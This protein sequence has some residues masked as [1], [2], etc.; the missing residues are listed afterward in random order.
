MGT[1]FLGL[2]GLQTPPNMLGLL[3][4]WE[5]KGVKNGKVTCRLF[6]NSATV[7]FKPAGQTPPRPLLCL[8]R[9]RL[10]PGPEPAAT[11][12]SA[13]AQRGANRVPRARHLAARGA[14]GG[15]RIQLQ[16]GSVHFQG[17]GSN[18]KPS[19]EAAWAPRPRGAPHL[20]SAPRAGGH[21]AGPCH[22]PALHPRPS[23]G[24]ARGGRGS[25]HAH[26]PA[27]LP[28]AHAGTPAPTPAPR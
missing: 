23:P 17:R 25:P 13:P 16:A 19:G 10:A 1:Q 14:P 20:P 24:T 9:H 12:A 11:T 4:E 22:A 2:L 21:S 3:E 15:Q 5:R 7:T 18:N 8:P 6:G 27:R 26:R 28:L